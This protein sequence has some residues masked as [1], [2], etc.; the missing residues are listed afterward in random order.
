[1]L[2]YRQ[3]DFDHARWQMLNLCTDP[4]RVYRNATYHS[5]TK[6]QWARDDP[7][8]VVIL[9][10]LLVVAAVVWS[11][12][13]GQYSVLAWLRLALYAIVVDFLLIGASVATAGWWL[14]NNYLH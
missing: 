3:M 10:L 8:I 11:V 13:F 4:K 2:R 1:M 14:S 7:A 9:M 5:R 6:H 12:A